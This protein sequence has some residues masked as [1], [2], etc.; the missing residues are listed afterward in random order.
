MAAGFLRNFD[1]R[2][3]VHSAGTS[4]GDSVNPK[5]VLVMSEAGIDISVEKPKSV[6]RYLKDSWDYVITVCDDAR[7]TCPFFPGKV[8]NRLHMGFEDPS[9]ATGTEV[10][11]MSEFRRIRDQIK[12]EFLRLYNEKIKNHS[13]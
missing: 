4:P 6:D 3:D 8:N 12:I 2:L 9:H 13:L 7:E 5:A 11:I 10:Y 1:N